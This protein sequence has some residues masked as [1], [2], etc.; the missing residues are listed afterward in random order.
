MLVS[1]SLC[2]RI[3]DYPPGPQFSPAQKQQQRQLGKAI[4]N[5]IVAAH[6]SGASSFTI[7]AANYRW[8]ADQG[9]PQDVY[10]VVLDSL[11]R[12]SGSTFTIYAEGTT[13]WIDTRSGGIEPAP[14]VTRGLRL[15]NCSNLRLSGLTIDFDPPNTIEG[16]VT[17][18]D[19]QGNRIQLQLS[20]GTLF[21][22]WPFDSKKLVHPNV[23]R[24]IPYKPNG[25]LIT[26][27]YAFQANAGL[28]FC[29]WTTP[30]SPVDGETTGKTIW[31]TLW[32]TKLLSTTSLRS[33]HNAFGS[34]GVMQV[35]DA[36]SGLKC[37]KCSVFYTLYKC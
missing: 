34:A 6:K 5:K 9:S 30:S 7:P 3:L 37:S 35:G 29:N 33:W 20:E 22:P 13:F 18:I 2:R 27:L 10:S 8:V 36:V 14:H 4:L 23:G 16:Q 21:R 11:R 19:F 15:V 31:A 24:F 17:Q 32:N 26:P 28:R 1:R 25:D 12:P